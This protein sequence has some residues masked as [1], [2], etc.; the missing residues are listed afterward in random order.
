MLPAVSCIDALALRA[1]RGPLALTSRKMQ[2]SSLE[3]SWTSVFITLAI[4]RSS[5]H[6]TTTLGVEETARRRTH[7][8]STAAMVAT[9]S[10]PTSATRGV[11]SSG[12][13][14]GGSRLVK[15]RQEPTLGPRKTPSTR[16]T[17]QVLRKLL[18]RPRHVT[19]VDVVGEAQRVLG[20]KRGVRR[21]QAQRPRAFY[22]FPDA[23]LT[24]ST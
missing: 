16:K 14:R 5:S 15:Q 8:Q 19:L 4:L 3:L 24:S 23:P 2:G 21:D 13:P 18:H 6:D 17:T 1:E 7:A 12:T 11:S 20:I 22:G 10:A 9:R